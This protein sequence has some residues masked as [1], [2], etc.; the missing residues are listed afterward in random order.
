MFQNAYNAGISE[1]LLFL[2]TLNKKYLDSSDCT[3][4]IVNADDLA[5]II[6]K[7][8]DE[9]LN[10]QAVES[11]NTAIYIYEQ[12]L[13]YSKTNNV[14][15]DFSPVITLL[16]KAVEIE[17]KKYFKKG[18]IS[19]LIEKNI[20]PI[21]LTSFN[22]LVIQSD[23]VVEYDVDDLLAFTMGNMVYVMDISLNP[24]KVRIDKVD[25]K[26]SIPYNG[27]ECNRIFFKT[28]YIVDYFNSIFKRNAF[29]IDNRNQELLKYLYSIVKDLRFLKD[30]LR[31]SAV[32]SSIM[33]VY[34]ANMAIDLIILS[35]RMIFSFKEKLIDA[36][37]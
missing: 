34:D 31:N 12:L 27:D 20:K 17:F 36:V 24:E 8:K 19:Y 9:M 5:K 4:S 26:Y 2:E 11:I 18:Y 37:K 7:S 23:R 1:A 10:P 30:Y 25:T 32:H 21:G 35:K 22:G 13:H 16:S 14:R 3:S 28:K 33:N 29:N 6:D 15:V